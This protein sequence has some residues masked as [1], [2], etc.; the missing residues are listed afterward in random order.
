MRAARHLEK[1]GMFDDAVTLFQRAGCLE[2]ALE[3][4][5]QEKNYET[6]RSIAE[7][8]EEEALAQVYHPHSHCVACICRVHSIY[9]NVRKRCNQ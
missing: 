6:L 8:M 1:I 3:I 4:C 9:T 7:E 5:F 2:R